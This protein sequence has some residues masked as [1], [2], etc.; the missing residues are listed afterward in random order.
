MIFEYDPVKSE[1]NRAKHGIDFEDAQAAWA[2]ADRLEIPAQTRGEERVALICRIGGKHWTVIFT[3]R[4]DRIR[5]ISARR[6]RQNEVA[7]YDDQN[8]R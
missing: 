2:D 7:L 5:L 6:A 1:S 3:R 4:G 8:I